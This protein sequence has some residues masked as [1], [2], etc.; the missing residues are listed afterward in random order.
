M[1][2]RV[3]LAE[4]AA[5]AGV[6]P[7]TVSRALRRPDTVQPETRARIDAAV[8]ALGYVPDPAARALATGR[9]DVIGVLIPSATNAVFTDVLSGIYDRLAESRFDVQYGITRYD[10]GTEESLLGVFLR[11]RPAGLIVAGIDQTAA[12]RRLLD[13][14]GCPVVQVM[15]IGA[16][17]VDM[18]VGFSHHDAAAAA[19]R[20]LIA[21]GYRRPG[22]LG[23]RM[24]PRT[25]RRFAG[26]RAEA[27]AAGIFDADR[28]ETTETP[29]NVGMG[30][31]LLRGLLERRPD[32]D[33][34]FCNNDDLALGA[35]FEAMRLG[36][37]VPGDLGI[38]GF[39]DLEM[40]RAAEPPI[41]SVRTNRFEMG[42]RA[43]EMIRA[44]LEGKDPGPAL[45]DLGSE[46]QARRSTEGPS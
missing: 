27:E 11:Q 39:N 19:T 6:S 10:P 16:D 37:A 9:S 25:R 44:R 12:A 7:I 13:R 35:L 15:E 21:Q 24:D 43:A 46:V 40:M 45:V 33:A 41:T 20:H 3:T 30:A 32:T 17:P 18:M 8:T 1:A 34:V 2:K 36:R 38:C 4:V 23:A 29:S 22:F 5:Q 28:C 14:A 26:F 42:A 31:A